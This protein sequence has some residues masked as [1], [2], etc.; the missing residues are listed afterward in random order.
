VNEGVIRKRV[1]TMLETG[2]LPCDEP[3]ETWAG[4]GEGQ[5]CAA[6]GEVIAPTELEFEVSLDPG[7]VLRLHRRCH[8]IWLE[9]CEPSRA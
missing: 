6:C 4:P 1:R 9:E 7:T 3:R 8:A 5:H 2:Q